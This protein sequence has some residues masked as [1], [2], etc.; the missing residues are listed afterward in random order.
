MKKQKND[1]EICLCNSCAS[2]FYNSPT[3]HISRVDP[4][5]VI[6]DTCDCCRSNR[7]YDFRLGPN[8]QTRRRVIGQFV[9]LNIQV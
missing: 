4:L 3:H 5:Q 2:V 7:G 6:K 8:I 9:Q 1:F